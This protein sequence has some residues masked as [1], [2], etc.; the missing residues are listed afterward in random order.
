M[1]MKRAI[2]LWISNSLKFMAPLFL[3]SW[4]MVYIYGFLNSWPA[5]EHA[6]SKFKNDLV[7]LSGLQYRSSGLYEQESRTYLVIQSNPLS[8]KTVKITT[9]SHG[10]YEV[11]E[12]AGGLT[13]A[14][15]SWMSLIVITWW[16]WFR[17]K[18]RQG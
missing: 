14:I 8:S 13:S 5:A 11:I 4:L 17:G 1:I 12:D 3:V 10:G 7:L 15:V 16:F 9:R 18:S 2:M 6:L